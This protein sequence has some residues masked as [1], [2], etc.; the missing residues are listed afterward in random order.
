[1]PFDPGSD[2]AAERIFLA[3]LAT[4]RNAPAVFAALHAFSNAILPVRLWTVMTV[5]ESAGLARRAYTNMPG[6]YPV[7]GTKPIVRNEWFDIVQGRHECFVANTLSDIARVFPD[8]ELI[9]SLGC[10]SVL[11]LPVVAGGEILATVN[12]LDGEGFFTPDRVTRLADGLALPAL[13]A[14]LA[15][16][17]LSS[18]VR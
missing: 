3:D 1:M 6:A 13:T 5:D 16:R 14:M 12:L 2:R 9:G 10:A 8:H 17:H 18:T 4:A 7:S 11:N 15:A